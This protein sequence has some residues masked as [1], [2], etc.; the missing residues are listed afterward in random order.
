MPSSGTG[1]S[2]QTDYAMC[3]RYFKHKHVDHI[4]LKASPE[5]AALAVGEAMHAYFQGFLVNQM[6]GRGWEE[7]AEA[8]VVSY[9]ALLR[10]GPQLEGPEQE[11]WMSR[12]ELAGTVLPMWATRQWAKLES[13]AERT[14]AVELDLA[15]ELPAETEYGPIAPHLRRYTARLD[16]VYEDTARSMVFVQDWKSTKALSPRE[17]ARNYQMSDQHL[18]YV[19]LWVAEGL[20]LG[21]PVGADGVVYSFIRLHPKVN[22]EHTFHD[23]ERVVNDA[24]LRDWYDRLLAARAQMSVQWDRPLNAWLPNR[25]AFG[26]CIKYGHECEFRRL[27][28]RPSDREAL[29]R[30][31]Y[32]VVDAQ[33]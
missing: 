32:E 31:Q 27:C 24:Q 20:R 7:C 6:E 30:D 16:R 9:E 28:M 1:N 22:S 12:I 3:Q 13:G 5:A 25:S 29:I 10:G 18:G 23:E 19:Y 17:I 33:P 14:L 26:P 21:L 4:A 11:E 2:Y 8:A 15:L